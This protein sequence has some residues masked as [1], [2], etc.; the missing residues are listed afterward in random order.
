MMEQKRIEKPCL[1]LVEGKNDEIFFKGFLNHLKIEPNLYD[2]W[3][4]GGKEKTLHTISVLRKTPGFGNLKLLMI[5]LDADESSSKTFERIKGA[6]CRTQL[7]VPVKQ[8]EQIHQSGIVVVAGTIPP[9]RENGT[10]ENLCFE[11]LKDD[12]KESI[13]NCVDS[14]FDCLKSLD[15]K[16]KYSDSGKTKFRIVLALMDIPGIDSAVQKGLFS[17]DSP[18]LLPLP[19]VLK[20]I[21][22]FCQ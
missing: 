18:F 2:V 8:F 10:L 21:E 14:L 3:C 20:N 7:P 4:G 12:Y 5:F 6:L 16:N 13:S 9:C 11:I 15:I 19:E 1:I 22:Q 17:F